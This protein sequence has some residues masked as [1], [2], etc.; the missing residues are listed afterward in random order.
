MAQLP[1]QLDDKHVLL[2]L[3]YPAVKIEQMAYLDFETFYNYLEKNVKK[4][5]VTESEDE[6]LPNLLLQVKNSL[7]L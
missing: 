4:V 1:K 3:G 6:E 7:N 2:E 5:M